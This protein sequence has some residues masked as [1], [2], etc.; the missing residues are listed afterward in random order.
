MHCDVVSNTPAL[1]PH[2][3]PHHPH[4]HQ[5]ST[6]SL[7]HSPFIHVGHQRRQ[8]REREERKKKR[9]GKDEEGGEEEGGRPYC[10]S[11]PATSCCISTMPSTLPETEEMSTSRSSFF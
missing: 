9:R 4:I 1:G 10:W 2:V 6:I 5:P 11:T 3:S 8:R 7:P